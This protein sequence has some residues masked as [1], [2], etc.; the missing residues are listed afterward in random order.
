[1]TFYVNCVYFPNDHLYHRYIG[2][3][4][5][6][7]WAGRGNFC[8]YYGAEYYL[9]TNLLAYGIQLNGAGTIYD[10]KRP[11]DGGFFANVNKHFDEIKIGS[12]MWERKFDAANIEEAIKIF[13]KQE[14]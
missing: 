2:L 7:K 9:D 1:M 4:D 11:F 12:E 14:W 6:N 10:P 3:F 8:G 5:S 13:E